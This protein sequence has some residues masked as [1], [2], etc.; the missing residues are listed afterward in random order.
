MS[1]RKPAHRRYSILITVG[2]AWKHPRCPLAREWTK[3]IRTTAYY[4]VLKR[5]GSSSHKKTRSEPKCLSPRGEDNLRSL[6]T[7]DS[8]SM[9]LLKRQ[10]C[11][12]SRR[13][14]MARV[15]RRDERAVPRGE[16]VKP[17]RVTL[18]Q[19]THG[20]EPREL[21]SPRGKADTHD[22]L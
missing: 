9:M 21:H 3:K 19:Q 11:R 13:S 20:S 10:N 12:D 4:S 15:G 16:A 6:Q 7:M 14:T 8:S 18:E 2:K 17:L 22:R 5:K 1:T